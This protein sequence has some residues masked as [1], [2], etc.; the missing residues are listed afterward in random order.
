M[1]RRASTTNVL[2]V[3]IISTISN[4]IHTKELLARLRK[5]ADTLSGIDQNDVSPQDYQ[6]LAADLA[7]KKLLRHKNPGIQAYVC[8]AITDILRIFAPEAPFS[9]ET[10]LEIF[11]AFL[12]Q[13]SLLWNEENP[14]FLQQ[15]YILKRIVEVRSVVLITDL[16]D[17][18]HIIEEMFDTMYSVAGK[19]FPSKLEPLAA[20]MLS[21]TISEADNVARSVVSLL[22]KKLVVPK[23]YPVARGQSNIANTAFVFSLTVCEGNIDKMARHVAQHFSEM[24]DASVSSKQKVSNFKASYSA[25]EK[26]HSYSVHIWAHIPELLNSVMGLISDELNSDNE[27][28][29][30][31]ATNSI[32][33]MLASSA[34]SGSGLSATRFISTHKTAW[35]NWLKKSS[36]VSV[37][38]RVGWVQQIIPIILSQ[39]LSIEPQNELSSGLSKSL[40][41]SSEKVRLAACMATK[42]L[43]IFLFIT[44]LCTAEILDSFLFL[45]REKHVDIRNEAINFLAN[46]YNHCLEKTLQDKV[47]DFGDLSESASAKMRNLITQA[48]PNTIILLIYVS[49]KLLTATVDVVLFEKLIPFIEDPALRMSRFC[50][51]FENLD[52]RGRAA[53]LAIANRQKKR[54]EVLLQFV[55]YA[56]EYALN[57]I[58]QPE[59]NVKTAVDAKNHR[60]KFFSSVEKIIQWLV[61]SFP[62]GIRSYE[63]IERFFRLKNLRLINLLKTSVNSQLDYKSIKNS[64]KEILLKVADDKV[65]KIEGDALRLPSAYMISSM[66][67]LL[68]RSSFIFYNKSNIGQIIE[69][70]ADKDSRFHEI[71]TIII[72]EISKTFPTG[73]KSH[74]NALSDIVVHC[75]N[76]TKRV[77]YLRALYH[78]GRKCPRNL[79]TDAHY[80]ECFKELSFNGSSTEARY[81]TKIMNSYESELINFGSTAPLFIPFDTT[82]TTASLISTVAEWFKYK[83]PELANDWNEISKFV[84]EHVLRKNDL[85]PGEINSKKNWIDDEDISNHP[86]LDMKLCSIRLLI[87]K[88]RSISE[89]LEALISDK[90]IKLLYAIISN[91]GEI[92]KA[93]MGLPTPNFYRARLRLATGLGVLKLAQN[94]RVNVSINHEEIWKLSRLLRDEN[95]AVR[96]GFFNSLKK[97]LTRNSIS[98]RFLFLVFLLGHDPID[99]VRD[100]VVKWVSS[101]H[102]RLE[103]KK[104]LSF[105]KSLTRLAYSISHDE[106]FTKYFQNE[107][108]A[109]QESIERKVEAYVYALKY[110]SMYLDSVANE[111]N[112]SML[113][114]FASRIKQYR[115]ATTGNDA[116]DTISENYNLYRIAELFQLMIKE[117]SDSKGWTLQSWPGKMNLY[118]DIFVLI[119]DFEEAQKV[120]STEYISGEV[121]VELRTFLAKPGA[122]KIKRKP[123]QKLAQSTAPKKRNADRQSNCESEPEAK[124]SVE[125]APR[126]TSSRVRRKVTYKESNEESLD[127][128]EIDD[129]DA[130]VSEASE[131]E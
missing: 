116:T 93:S 111:G 99:E 75:E 121:Q 37:V 74:A 81:A 120:I 71:S 98:E 115:A 29:R 122:S 48:I 123:T 73:F 24:L 84:I 56:E 86:S 87:N 13:F 106:I 124:N 63:C 61:D 42:S 66:K 102:S 82:R 39:S 10:L 100:D 95:L 43:P 44:K 19:G 70:C 126:R 68:Y 101:Q 6:Q 91:N 50:F 128:G 108:N 94:P 78:F 21:E 34:S 58:L 20:E 69:F 118:F 119:D 127:K 40:M 85:K 105:E 5:I 112:L 12:A 51:L 41:D 104:D 125:H 35:T 31:L 22:L 83:V 9:P 64:I 25:L 1:A 65:L 90:V 129:D 27:K 130:A 14:Y 53:F 15:C 33:S 88:V 47:I 59:K 76:N 57:N 117:F 52:T 72:S 49:D 103:A 110:I 32:G 28:I 18:E 36:D 109:L 38:V 3:P 7:S 54:V 97:Y 23:N 26:I 113:Y 77:S 131:F 107:G 80:L 16:P 67:L 8:C 4:Q 96:R 45:C 17:S 62:T 114:Y 2:T 55:D 60:E 92:V 30:L 11:R 46:L 89:P 79:P